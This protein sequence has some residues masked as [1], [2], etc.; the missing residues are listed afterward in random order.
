MEPIMFPDAVAAVVTFL[1][2]YLLEPVRSAV[3]NP[4][5]TAFYT[6]RRTGGPRRNLVTDGA[7]ITVESWAQT[8]EDAQDMAQAARAY[9]HTIVGQTV[10]GA[11]VYRCDEL[12]GPAL[13]PDP[14]SNQPRYSQSFEIAIRGETLVGS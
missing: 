1:D 9:L 14:L 12:A 3:P 5:P 7:Q 6:V 4:R 10:N 2:T 8:D 13:L 11:P